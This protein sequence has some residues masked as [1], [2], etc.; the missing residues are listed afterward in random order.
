MVTGLFLENSYKYVASLRLTS[1]YLSAFS[2]ASDK[3]A[4]RRGQMLVV[5]G[6][7]GK[8]SGLRCFWESPARLSKGENRTHRARHKG[9]SKTKLC[10]ILP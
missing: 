10:A 9:K 3:P 6:A 2:P 4:K 7:S 1:Y 8:V 5:N